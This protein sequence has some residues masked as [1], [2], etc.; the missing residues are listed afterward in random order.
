MRRMIARSCSSYRRRPVADRA[1]RGMPYLRSQ[2]RRRL[3]EMPV[4]IAAALTVYFM[5]RRINLLQ[6]LCNPP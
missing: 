1:G 6:K 2:V 5:L 4:A 3:S